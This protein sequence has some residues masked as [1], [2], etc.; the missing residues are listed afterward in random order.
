MP[1]LAEKWEVSPDGKIY[2]FKLR[3]GV[4]FHDG[5]P[6]S[7]DDVLATFKRIINPPSGIVSLQPRAL[8]RRLGDRGARREDVQDR[9]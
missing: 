8:R 4:K 1:D 6:F 9:R 2:T 5:T 3:E 7:S